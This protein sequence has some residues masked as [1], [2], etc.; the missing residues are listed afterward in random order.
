MASLA[1]PGY[2]PALRGPL[3]ES[4]P[5]TLGADLTMAVGRKDFEAFIG[6]VNTLTSAEGFTEGALNYKLELSRQFNE[7][8]S[9]GLSSDGVVSWLKSSSNNIVGC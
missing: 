1:T 7:M 9:A 2:V 4:R 3:V 6:W 8:A 5:I